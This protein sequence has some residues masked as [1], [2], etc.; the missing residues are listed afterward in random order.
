M[1]VT[2]PALW[3]FDIVAALVGDENL[4]G[5]GIDRNSAGIDS[6]IDR[7]DNGVCNTIDNRDRARIR[8]GPSAYIPGW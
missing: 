5:R 2:V 1:T 4:V 3:Q 7:A 8:T 6:D